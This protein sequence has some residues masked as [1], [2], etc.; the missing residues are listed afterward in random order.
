MAANAADLT[1]VA[2]VQAQLGISGSTD[3]LLIQVLVTAYSR[4]ILTRCGRRVLNGMQTFTDLYDGIGSYKQYVADWPI[5][6]ISALKVFG[7]T[8]PQSPD[9]INPGWVVGDQYAGSIALLPGTS[10][11]GPISYAAWLMPLGRFPKAPQNVSVSFTAGYAIAAWANATAYTLGTGYKDPNNN[12][13]VVT[14]GGTSGASQPVWSTIV[15]GTTTD[16][17]VTWTN[18]GPAAYQG[19]LLMHPPSDPTFNGA[20]SE[21]GQAVTELV[22]QQYRRREWVDQARKNIGP[23]GE[24]IDFRSW[25]MPPWLTRVIENYRRTWWV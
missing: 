15:G 22:V 24:S 4:H 19:S 18:R 12:I 23:A 16:G 3:P 25:E 6:S 7:Q 11:G 8:I 5:Q 1:T 2:Q 13:Q 9:G 21:L 20:P 14:T 17:T 10:I